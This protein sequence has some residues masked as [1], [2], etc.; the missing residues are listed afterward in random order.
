MKQPYLFSQWGDYHLTPN[1]SVKEVRGIACALDY[2]R[3]FYPII[4]FKDELHEMAGITVSYGALERKLRLAAAD[5][6]IRRIEFGKVVKY[7]HNPDY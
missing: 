4:L 2:L 6:K 1:D 7:Q 3:A 5:K